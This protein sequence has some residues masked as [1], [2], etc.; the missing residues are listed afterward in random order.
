MA[1]DNTW[2]TCRHVMN[3]SAEH[4]ILRPDK[5][6]VCSSCA[7]N[8]D[9]VE[10]EEVYTLDKDRLEFTLESFDGIDV[11]ENIGK[12]RDRLGRIV[13]ENRNGTDRRSGKDR[14]L[15]GA[16]SYNG[17]ERRSLKYRRSGIDR[18]TTLE[19]DFA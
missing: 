6:C 5:M 1:N 2:I 7:E 15:G 8:V 19:P 4:V 18:R 3:G 16:S 10:T 9:I 12:I 14:R 11:L 13:A 17:P